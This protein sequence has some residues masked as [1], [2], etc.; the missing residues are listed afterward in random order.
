MMRFA[1]LSLLNL[2]YTPDRIYLSME[3]NMS[4][5]VGKCGHCRVGAYYAC[6]DGPVFT[7]EQVQNVTKI[8]H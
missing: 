6:K 4:C 3:K 2:G 5:G 1:T 8:W 7:F